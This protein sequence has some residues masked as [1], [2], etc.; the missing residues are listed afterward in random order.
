[1]VKTSPQPGK[2]PFSDSLFNMWRCIIMMAHADGVI[3][4]KE[5][6]FFDKVFASMGRTYALSPQHLETFSSDLKK[7]QDIEA[8]IEGI[9][10]PE[11]RSLL[12][13]FA[14]IVAWI[15]GNLSPDESELLKKLHAKLG[16]APKAGEM[17][18]QIRQDIADQMQRRKEDVEIKHLERNPLFYALDALLLRLGIEILD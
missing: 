12:L 13:Y 2:K 6:E 8:L 16:R 10:D 1:M 5:Q 7:A 9:S 18:A 15:D 4:E 3:H 17:M 14:Q 11:Y